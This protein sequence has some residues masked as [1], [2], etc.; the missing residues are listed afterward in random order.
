MNTL[1]R[2]YI[3]HVRPFYDI[4]IIFI[5]VLL[6]EISATTIDI[7]FFDACPVLR[8]TNFS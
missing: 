6:D 4:F 3:D 2:F 1:W 5:D 7:C 8:P